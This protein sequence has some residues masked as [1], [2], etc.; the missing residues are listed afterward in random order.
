VTQL[1][2]ARDRHVLVIVDLAVGGELHAP[3]DDADGE[4]EI[5]GHPLFRRH[6]AR[7]RGERALRRRSRIG[8]AGGQTHEGEGGSERRTAH[9]A[10]CFR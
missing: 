7:M 3:F 9:R 6:A 2:D 1:E 10:Q 4:D 8:R 5:R